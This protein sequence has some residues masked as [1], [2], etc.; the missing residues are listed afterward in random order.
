MNLFGITFVLYLLKLSA[1][2]GFERSLDEHICLIKLSVLYVHLTVIKL[3]KLCF[4][5]WCLVIFIIFS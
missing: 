5:T 1:G 4:W 2:N 3:M